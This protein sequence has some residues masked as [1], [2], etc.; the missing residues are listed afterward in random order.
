[1]R[2]IY[3]IVLGLALVLL[4][5]YLISRLPI[6]AEKA[7]VEDTAEP[8]VNI[9]YISLEEPFPP[10]NE[11][12][13]NL[14]TLEK[15]ALGRLLFFDPV[16]SEKNDIACASCHWPELGLSDGRTTSIGISGNS[17]PR[18]APTLWNVGYVRN[19]FWDGRVKSLEAQVIFPL[20]NLDEM[21]V[22]DTDVLAAELLTYPE[23][24]ALF[25]DAFPSETISV[26]QIG[27][28]LAAYQRTFISD[29]SPFDRYAA[30]NLEAL[31][32]AQ[33][34]GL[35]LFR[36]TKTHCVDCHTFPTF[37]SESF[38][39]VGVESDDVGRAAVIENGLIGSFD[40]VQM[41]AKKPVVPLQ[42]NKQIAPVKHNK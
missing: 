18:N 11:P 42:F 4:L 34:R 14:S 12:E 20:T 19:L 36:S 6:F 16:L 30:G 9:P 21:G 1:M 10:L 35:A 31:T 24:A 29:D 15:V 13:D 41:R 27:K 39:V 2:R 28:A 40:M 22:R 25:A 8:L 23:Y 17:V 33:Q 26:A 32:P 3:V 37:S 38:C 7:F 5:A